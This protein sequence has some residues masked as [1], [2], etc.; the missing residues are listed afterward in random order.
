MYL[1]IIFKIVFRLGNTNVDKLTPA[2]QN[3]VDGVMHLLHYKDDALVTEAVLPQLIN[4]L[5][6]N[7][8]DAVAHAASTIY[9]L[10]RKEAP[11]HALTQNHELCPALAH[12]LLDNSVKSSAETKQQV[13]ATIV[14]LSDDPNGRGALFRGQTISALVRMLGDPHEPIVKYA[15]STLHNLLTFMKQDVVGPIRLAGGVSRMAHLMSPTEKRY[16]S[17]RFYA[18]LCSSLEMLCMGDIGSKSLVADGNALGSLSNHVEH[19][20]YEKLSYTSVRLLCTLSAYSAIKPDIIQYHNGV[21]ALMGA[22]KSGANF[23]KPVQETSLWALRNL[24]DKVESDEDIQPLLS[25]CL[26][27]LSGASNHADILKQC[28]AGI[29]CNLTC[30]SESNKVFVVQNGGVDELIRTISEYV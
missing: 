26:H 4:M 30:N 7:D 19:A 23:E 11:R 12:V 28:A 6:H 21:R 10:A 8:P 25:E 9:T 24:S 1:R 16:W 5:L 2:V 18:I 22:Y 14:A 15:L 17:D 20:E 27:I 13:M 29:L 3:L